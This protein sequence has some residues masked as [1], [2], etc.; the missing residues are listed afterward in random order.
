MATASGLL[1]GKVAI[2]TGAGGGIGRQ[3]AL[4]LA[5]EG[6]RVVV[7]DVGG[8]RDGTGASPEMAAAVVEEIRVAGG[9]AVANTDTV[10]TVEGGERIVRTALDRFG[11]LDVL[12]NNAG[13]LRDKTLAKM[14][15]DLWDAVIA[16][17]LKG[18]YCVT[19]PAFVHMKERG[20]G[21]SIINTSSTS[22]LEG[23][24]GQTNYG[25]AKAGI[26]G[27]TRCLALEGERHGIRVNAIAPV[28][29]TR[30]T[31]DLAMFQADELKSRMDPRWISPL[32]VFLASDLA[33]GV[34]KRIFFVGGGQIAEMRMVRTEG[35]TKPEA[36]G[37]WTA[38][39]IAAQLDRILA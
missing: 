35:V 3:H 31:E 15:D 2:V 10:A 9:E 29:L 30:M 39:E 7:N 18:T 21:G 20:D 4:A 11:R 28:A 36:E 38:E 19:R 14:D 17:H 22:G 37:L 25:A 1:E 13:I 8:A 26:A 12:V 5:A 23:N 34:T 33:R 27:F 16:V 24:F 6:A 32:V